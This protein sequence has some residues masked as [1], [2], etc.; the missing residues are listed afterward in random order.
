MSRKA[1]ICT[2]SMNSLLHGNRSSKEDRFREATEKMKKG[3]L[4]KPDLFLLPEIFLVN[5]APGC[6]ADP[7]NIETEGNETYQRL[8]ATAR[9]Y[10]AYV[11]AALLTRQDGVPHNSIVIFD[12]TGEPVFY[13]HKT[14]PT[15]GEIEQGISPGP[16]KP[17]CFDADFGRIG[18]A[19][20]YDLN[21]QPLFR[22]YYDQGVELLLFSSYF[23]GGLLL[24]SWCY[25]Y[26][27]HAVT[28]HAQGYESVFVDNMGH[29]QA[30]AN[31]FAQVLTHE[32]ELD[33]V[34]VPYYGNH[35]EAWAAK[36][37]YGPDL[38]L[39][40]HRAEGDVIIRYTGTKTTAKE[41]LREFGLQ[42]RVECYKNEHLL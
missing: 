5:D 17:A 28:S 20:C 2:I 8:G 3:S 34:V 36:E 6:Y 24:Q 1:R 21:F 10:G 4:D 23:P 42:T 39:D 32:F 31:M 38:E 26:M 37:K 14:F 7:A 41:I 27:F 25:L 15:A 35:E 13:Y 12:R 29:V 16:R 19:I 22:H 33:S 40:I 11:A 18:V 30:R 9:S